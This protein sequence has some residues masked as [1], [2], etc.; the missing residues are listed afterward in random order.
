MDLRPD[1]FGK[2][3]W[4]PAMARVPGGFGALRPM[5]GQGCAVPV[6]G[7]ALPVAGG[8]AAA[9]A[10]MPDWAI[11]AIAAGGVAVIAA[12]LLATKVI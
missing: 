7:Q 8:G 4:S 3:P 12:V 1:F 6:G 11:P 9:A 5:L 2:T 10:P